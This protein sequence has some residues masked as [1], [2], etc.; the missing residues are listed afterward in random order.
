MLP[1]QGGQRELSA[2]L[3]AYLLNLHAAGTMLPFAVIEAATGKAVGMTTY[4]NADAVNKRVEIGATWYRKR[5]QR[6]DLNTNCKLLLLTHAF[7]TWNL[8]RVELITDIR[9]EQSRAAILRLGAKQEGIL[10]KHMVTWNGRP[11][12]SV[13][14][15][16]LDTE[17]AEVKAGLGK[18]LARKPV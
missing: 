16:I 18:K 1:R 14:F 9:N 3:E 4:M 7:E 15:S 6:T 2:Q 13:Y 11:R 10:R 5:V 12:N 17:W 8:V